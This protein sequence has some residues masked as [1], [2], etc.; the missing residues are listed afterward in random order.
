VEAAA[1]GCAGIVNNRP[2][3]EAPDQPSSL[4]L[5]SEARRHG[6]GYWHLPIV[7][8]QMSEK[9]V[10]DFAGLLEQ[11]GG[12]LLAFCRTGHRSATLFQAAQA[13]S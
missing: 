3:G 1:A 8:G 4:E 9:D 7:P 13:L 11:A 2:D 5:E 12:P 6:L 10:R